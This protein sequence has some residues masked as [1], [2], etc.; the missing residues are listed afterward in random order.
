[1]ITRCVTVRSV[2]SAAASGRGSRGGTGRIS[3]EVRRALARNGAD[4]RPLLP[5]TSSFSGRFALDPLLLPLFAV[6][7]RPLVALEACAFLAYPGDTERPMQGARP[8]TI[9][10]YFG[11]QL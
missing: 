1:M 11:R 9:L 6:I 2:V 7:S 8:V 3:A 4:L 10:L 5:P